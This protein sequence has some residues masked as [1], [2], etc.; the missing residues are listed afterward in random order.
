MRKVLIADD[1]EN[2][3]WL[4]KKLLNWE[5]LG[6]EYGG[7]VFDGKTAYEKI[8]S[9]NPDIVITDVRMPDMDGLE[10]IRAARDAGLQTE[11]E[12]AY[13]ALKYGVEDYLL[14][15]VKK[16][17]LNAILEKITKRFAQEA[18]Y[19][20]NEQ[21]LRDAD[22]SRKAEERARF[23]KEN[24]ELP[25]ILDDVDAVNRKYGT[26]FREGIF[27]ALMIRT[28]LV[29]GVIG[30]VQ[31]DFVCRN[32]AEQLRDHVQGICGEFVEQIGDPQVTA[33]M[34]DPPL[35]LSAVLQETLRSM[36]QYADTMECYRVSMSISDPVTSI[37][38]VPQAI[39]EAELLLRSLILTEQGKVI[40]KDNRPLGSV[41]TNEELFPREQLFFVRRYVEA[42]DVEALRAQIRSSFRELEA[43]PLRSA[44]SY[45]RL[46]EL[47]AETA[48][49]TMEEHIWGQEQA[50][51]AR[52]ILPKYLENANSVT[53][54][55]SVLAEQLALT[56]EACREAHRQSTGRPIRV[57]RDFMEQ[58]MSEH[59]TLEQV[60]EEA[61]L[62]PAYFS[63]LFKQETGLTFSD[64]LLDRRIR[65]ARE[66][67][68]HT[69]ETVAA[70][71]EEVGYRDIKHFRK[72]FT[73]KVGVTPAKYRKLHA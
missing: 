25:Q 41:E 56:L 54:L 63:Q 48:F 61:A 59:L 66:L 30:Q 6:L 26:R 34:N 27:R 67:L 13:N 38:E 33:V 29:P 12:Y 32:L 21:A 55:R 44:T 16:K 19:E 72:V 3:C 31:T 28:D 70:I 65:K 50:R 20:Q 53:E 49:R 71:M 24:K 58:Q 10:M 7:M 68:L 69:D 4:I 64:Y 40:K 35:N 37:A 52:G 51:E 8:L 47:I 2:I 11:F 15:P 42:L 57:A 36:I 60:A 43:Q 9:E 62:S 17:E 23:I 22:E 45:Y 18:Q 5:G 73:D 46:A 39:R 1:E 14:K